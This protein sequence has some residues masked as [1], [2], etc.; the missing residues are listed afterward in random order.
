MILNVVILSIQWS[1]LRAALFTFLQECIKTSLLNIVTES[2]VALIEAECN[3]IAF[4]LHDTTEKLSP[5]LLIDLS[6]EDVIFPCGAFLRVLADYIQMISTRVMNDSSCLDEILNNVSSSLLVL[7]AVE[8]PVHTC[9]GTIHTESIRYID[10]RPTVAECWFQTL[11]NILTLMDK[12]KTSPRRFEHLEQVLFLAVKLSVQIMFFHEIDESS[13]NHQNSHVGMSVDGPQTFAMMKFLSYCFKIVGMN[14]FKFIALQFQS[15]IQLDVTHDI[16]ENHFGGTIICGALFR[17]FSGSLPPWIIE[18]APELY[19]SIYQACG[20]DLDFFHSIMVMGSV[21]RIRGTSSVFSHIRVGEKLGG[22]LVQSQQI[23]QL[24]SFLKIDAD[25]KQL[26]SAIKAACG[27]KKKTSSF[28][29]KPT[30]TT[31]QFDRI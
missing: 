19:F 2:L 13:I 16:S 31:W 8:K 17:A 25:W 30:S 12:T 1:R 28:A 15:I 23:Q 27:G 10:P 9:L 29:N 26:K 20:A 14:T 5:L 21:V 3:A 11:S 7:T 4:H 22:C 6:S 24:R 18:T